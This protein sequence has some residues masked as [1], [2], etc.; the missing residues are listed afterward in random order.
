[1]LTKAVLAFGFLV[2]L[3]WFLSP[4]G[5]KENRYFVHHNL[6]SQALIFLK[7]RTSPPADF[8]FRQNPSGQPLKGL[9]VALDPGHIGGEWAEWEERLMHFRGTGFDIRE[10]N[11]TMSTALRLK[12]LLSEQGANVFLARTKAGQAAMAV[13]FLS[14]RNNVPKMNQDYA[15]VRD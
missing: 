2:T 5:S 8:P 4:E 13:G 15:W 12:E 3:A 6:F 1:M 11:I 14:W 10:G 9:R 7:Y